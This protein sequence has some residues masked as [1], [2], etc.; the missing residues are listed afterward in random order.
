MAYMRKL[1]DKCYW[2]FCEKRA[3]R[4][5][6]GNRNE[7]YGNYCFSHAK[8]KVKHLK[9]EELKLATDILLKEVQ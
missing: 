6:F 9:E 7:N 2:H 1:D 8:A 4:E 3:T 5:V